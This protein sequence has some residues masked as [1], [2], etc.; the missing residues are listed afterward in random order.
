MEIVTLDNGLRLFFDEREEMRSATVG[1]WVASGSRN[2]NKNNNGI[3]HFI[4]HILFKGSKKRTGFEILP[5]SSSTQRSRK[6]NR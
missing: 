5:K 1:I 4:E 3:S 6:W 2:E